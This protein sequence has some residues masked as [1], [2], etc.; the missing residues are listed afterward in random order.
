MFSA[1]KFCTKKCWQGT[2]SMF[3]PDVFA[4]KACVGL[5]TLLNPMVDKDAFSFEEAPFFIFRK[6]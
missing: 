5:Q 1:G 6:S 4:T 2:T 3:V